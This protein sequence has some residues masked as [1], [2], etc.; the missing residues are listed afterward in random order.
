MPPTRTPHPHPDKKPYP[1][2]APSAAPTNAA[3][4]ESK[5]RA[6]TA[7]EYLALFEHIT[8]NGATRFEDAVPGRT[9]NQCY[10]AFTWVWVKTV[11]R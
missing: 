5:P 8:K 11:G 7:D 2:A 3:K 4:S 6:W 1:A 10:K 9:R